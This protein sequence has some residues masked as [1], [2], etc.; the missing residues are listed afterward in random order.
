[1]KIAQIFPG[2]FAMIFLSLASMASADEITKE[3]YVLDSRGNVVR[4]GYN[5]CWHTSFWTPEMAIT[6][7][8]PDLV[9]KNLAMQQKNARTRLPVTSSGK[10]A[11]VPIT[12]QTETLF[13]F[14]KTDVR[15]DG[16]KILDDE[17]VARMRQYPQIKVLLLAAHADR[18]G[19]TDYNMKLSQRRADAVKIYL[20]G[21]GIE[22][23]RIETLAKGE[24]EPVV[25]CNDVKGAKNSKRQKLIECLQPNR[26][27]VITIKTQM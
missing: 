19:G 16:K 3:G 4:S 14:D 5:E 21:H 11:F 22:E 13:D 7:C 26:R 12:L 25:S 20:T 1:M 8:E 17:V 10:A 23:K 6:E 2:M 18:I 15:V 9:K 27:V 24:S